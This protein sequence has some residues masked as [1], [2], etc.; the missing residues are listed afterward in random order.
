M[1]YS[2]HMYR[3]AIHETSNS[4]GNCDGA[5]CADD[6]DVCNPIYSVTVTRMKTVTR[7]HTV[8]VSGW[9]TLDAQREVCTDAFC[10][11]C[12]GRG[13]YESREQA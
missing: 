3:G 9:A 11:R 7:V 12:G 4:C 8:I 6:D 13:E 1:E 10:T 2:G 5:N